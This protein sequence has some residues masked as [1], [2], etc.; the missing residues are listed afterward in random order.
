[1]PN[2]HQMS[3]G[4]STGRLLFDIGVLCLIGFAAMDI[5][6]RILLKRAGYK[7]AFLRAYLSYIEYLRMKDGYGWS[8]WPV[9]VMWV[10]LGLGIVLVF[11]A[12]SKYGFFP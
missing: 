9:Y 4:S 6:F 12:A 2:L 8:A 11:V 3:V 5:L 1:M 10:I 7:K